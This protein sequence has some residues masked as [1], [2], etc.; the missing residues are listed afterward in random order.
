MAT[1]VPF[2]QYASHDCFA[3]SHGDVAF[4]RSAI[5]PPKMMMANGPVLV[6]FG[7]V[8][9]FSSPCRSEFI[10]PPGGVPMPSG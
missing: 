1:V 2:L 9:A 8:A 5:G 6:Q 4:M 3:A 10:S 7:V